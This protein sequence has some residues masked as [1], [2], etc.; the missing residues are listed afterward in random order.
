MPTPPNP[1]KTCTHHRSGRN[2]AA[3]AADRERFLQE[4]EEDAEMRA[5][6]ALFKDNAAAAA[7][8]A[9]PAGMMEDGD[10][11][12]DYGDLPHVRG[13]GREGRRIFLSLYSMYVQ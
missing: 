8:A 7:A 11:D 4:L 6:V 3:E 9:V 10:S 5:R 12:E 1:H 2:E 13:T